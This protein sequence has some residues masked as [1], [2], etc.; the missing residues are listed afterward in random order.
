M[1]P[2]TKRPDKLQLKSTQCRIDFVDGCALSFDK[3]LA[4]VDV[5]AVRTP[6][7]SNYYIKL[8]LHNQK[9]IMVPCWF[10]SDFENNCR[11][12]NVTPGLIRNSHCFF[13]SLNLP[14]VKWRIS[15]GHPLALLQWVLLIYRHQRARGVMVLTVPSLPTPPVFLSFYNLMLSRFLLSALMNTLQSPVM[16]QRPRLV[17]FP[18]SNHQQSNITSQ[19]GP[20]TRPSQASHLLLVWSLVSRSHLSH[21]DL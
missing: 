4:L 7:S 13:M 8:T 19:T 14:L 15:L 6:F 17:S 12:A 2:G 11:Q 20:G 21:C 16:E 5:S 9:Y 1:K 18:R 3:Y 10:S